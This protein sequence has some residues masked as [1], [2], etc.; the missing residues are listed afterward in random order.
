MTTTEEQ[1]FSS[2]SCCRGTKPH[3]P[4]LL[5]INAAATDPIIFY[6]KPTTRAWASWSTG[7][8]RPLSIHLAAEPTAT[9][10]SDRQAQTD[11]E[12]ERRAEQSRHAC[13]P[14]ARCVASGKKSSCLFALA[15]Q[16]VIQRVACTVF[17]TTPSSLAS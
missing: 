7:T 5:A 16:P 3:A 2:S 14:P 8:H 9:E 15:R 13:V 11:G 10:Q 6:L 1:H 4:I 12:R 17:S